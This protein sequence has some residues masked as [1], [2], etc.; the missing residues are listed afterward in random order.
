MTMYKRLVVAALILFLSSAAALI[1]V[2]SRDRTVKIDPAQPDER[3]LGLSIAPFSAVDQ[4]GHPV[5]REDLNGQLTVVNFIFTHCVLV[6]PAMTDTLSK[7]V[8][9]LKG[10][11]TRFLS[12]SIDP[13]HDTPETLKKFAANYDADHTRWRFAVAPE[14]QIETLLRDGL[15]FALREDPDPANRI[16]LPGDDAGEM[17]NIIHPSWFVLVG[18]DG[19]VLGVYSSTSFEE[20]DALVERARA[21]DKP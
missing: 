20:I 12:L 1:F 2:A 6:C 13:R 5:T 9:R 4:D 7:V 16:K 15:K 21:L 11:R 14:G 3:V 18:R 17:S 19:K 10:T 8:D